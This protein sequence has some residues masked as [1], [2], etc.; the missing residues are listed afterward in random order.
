MG[1]TLYKESGP[2]PLANVMNWM[3]DL[4]GNVSSPNRANNNPADIRL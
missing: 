2:E 1:D 3:E 4:A